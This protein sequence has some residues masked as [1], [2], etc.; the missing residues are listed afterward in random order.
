MISLKCDKCDVVHLSYE[1]FLFLD[2]QLQGETVQECLQAY[3]QTD[4]LDENA[5]LG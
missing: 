1:P 5:R 2:L 4:M 3:V